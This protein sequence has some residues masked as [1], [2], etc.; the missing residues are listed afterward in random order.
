[1]PW[2]KRPFEEKMDLAQKDAKSQ[3]A[4]PE[5]EL[6]E[7]EDHAA[8]EHLVLLELESIVDASADSEDDDQM[9]I[10]QMPTL[11][12]QTALLTPGQDQLKQHYSPDA[13]DSMGSDAEVTAHA[14]NQVAMN[15]AQ[16]VDNG[17][18]YHM[19]VNPWLVVSM[20]FLAGALVTIAMKCLLD[21][22]DQE[23][24][25]MKKMEELLQPAL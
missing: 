15:Q 11:H 7:V 16:A 5:V 1:V 18:V 8:D 20:C 22:R 14:P 24:R 21:K 19:S 17:A 23:K 12:R 10:V 9:P 13:S 25:K 2:E 4:K 6:I 3:R